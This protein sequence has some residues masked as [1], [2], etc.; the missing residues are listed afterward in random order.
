MQSPI[1]TPDQDSDYFLSDNIY[2]YYLLL[3]F[4]LVVFFNVNKIVFKSEY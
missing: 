2:R 4:L 1:L 3:I